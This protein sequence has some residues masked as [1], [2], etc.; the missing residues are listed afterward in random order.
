[1]AKWNVCWNKYICDFK[2]TWLVTGLVLVNSLALFGA[3]LRLGLW[4]KVTMRFRNTVKPAKTVIGHQPNCSNVTCGVWKEWMMASLVTMSLCH[5]VH[6]WAVAGITTNLA[7]V[8]GN[9]WNVPGNNHQ[10]STPLWPRAKTIND[11]I[12]SQTS[13]NPYFS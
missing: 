1:M 8:T 11:Y 9:L 6:C 12:Y 5:A 2:M 7:V 3:S 4:T 13:L 10:P